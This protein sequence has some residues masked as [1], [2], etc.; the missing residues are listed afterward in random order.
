M[1]TNTIYTFALL[2][3]LL[4]LLFGLGYTVMIDPYILRKQQHIILIIIILTLSLI[5]QN[6]IE[7]ALF[8]NRSN[9]TVKKLL[10]A[11]GYTVRPVI[12]ILF[13]YLI[14]PNGRKWPEWVL[15]GINAALYFSSPV[16]KLCFDI[17]GSDYFSL[18]GPLWMTCYAVSAFL[19]GELLV[20]TIYRY[21]KVKKLEQ[22]LPVAASL[23][24]VFSVVLDFRILIEPPVSFL[25]IAVIVDSVFFY[26]W[27]HLQ[28]VREHEQ[29]LMAA[30]R[31]RI[32]MT[33]IQPHFLFN[34]LNTIRSLYAIDPSKADAT[35]ENFSAYLRQNLESLNQT[36]LI[37]IAKELEHTQVY[38]EIEMVRFPNIHVEYQI[39]DEQ[40]K[41]PALT[42]QPLVENAIQH[43]VRGKK[44]GLVTVSS[45]RET[46]V[47]RVTVQ[48]NG[49]GFDVKKQIT[50]K[51][52]H[53][54]LQNVKE[55]VEQMCRGRMLL[56]SEIGKGTS[57][58]LLIPCGSGGDV[59]GDENENDLRG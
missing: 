14:H 19:L 57:V 55:R 59:G 29:D 12:L 16:T 13:L 52:Q 8:V 56:Q 18:R 32:M 7:E 15:A 50:A 25:T 39:E 48:D 37:P 24:I 26:I 45:V 1:S 33:Q 40:F 44:E 5:A 21:R 22:L 30:Q 27:L 51:G 49:L 46:D 4:L 38:A 9:L 47:H 3:P 2:Y 6:M 10:S 20:Q 53:I 17:R 42:I 43:G 28:Y 54:G 23:I 36:D 11:Y 58:T 34:S 35:L 31:I 41:I